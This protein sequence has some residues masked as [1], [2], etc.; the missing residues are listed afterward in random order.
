MF[1]A[2]LCKK[3]LL[4]NRGRYKLNGLIHEINLAESLW[5][6]NGCFAV[7]M[8]MMMMMMS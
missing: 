8:M 3:I 7:V 2:L 5:L 1:R 6:K 4:G